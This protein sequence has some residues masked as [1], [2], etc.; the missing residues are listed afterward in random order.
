MVNIEPKYPMV[1][2]ADEHLP[3]TIGCGAEMFGFS[4]NKNNVLEIFSMEIGCRSGSW[5]VVSN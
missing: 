3:L 4:Q 2:G 1:F 5:V